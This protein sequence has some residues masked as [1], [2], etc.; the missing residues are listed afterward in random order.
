MRPYC[1]FVNDKVREYNDSFRHMFS[2][3][4]RDVIWS[5]WD[6]DICEDINK[7]VRRGD[8]MYGD[9]V[10]EVIKLS[11]GRMFILVSENKRMIRHELKNKLNILSGYGQILNNNNIID[12]ID[13]M[14]KY[15][16]DVLID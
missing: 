13:D 10:L 5:V 15:I 12:V 9:R 1:L 8:V 3:N 2:V 11:K 7:V 14:I 16:D 4:K 6:T